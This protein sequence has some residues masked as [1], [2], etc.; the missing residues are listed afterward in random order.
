[1][2][3]KHV[4]SKESAVG[5][6]GLISDSH[7]DA[8]RT[9]AAVQCLCEA[10][11]DVLVHLGDIGTIGVIDAMAVADPVRGGMLEIHMVFGNTDWDLHTLGRYAADLGMTVSHPVGTLPPRHSH[12]RPLV[13]C[14]GHDPVAMSQAV[15]QNVRYLCHGHTHEPRDEFSGHT[16]VINPGALHR[17]RRYTAALLDT[18]TDDLQWFS[19]M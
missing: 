11:I 18:Q 7:G 4:V 6:I 14:H 5:R 13:F 8:K 1:V 15:Q 17:A 12:D 9:G 2:G 19:F 3:L 16:R 10:G